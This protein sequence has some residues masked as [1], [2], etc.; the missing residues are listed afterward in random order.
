MNAEET[1][2]KG[3]R[4]LVYLASPYTDANP[5]VMQRRFELVCLYAARLMAGGVHLF[6]PIAHGHAI[7]LAG[8]LPRDWEYWGPLSRK[9]LAGCTELWVLMLPGWDLSKGIAAEIQIAEELG[10]LVSYIEPRTLYT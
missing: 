7:A 3:E 4:R 2:R 8:T 1:Q 9:M 6:C 5:E 10:L